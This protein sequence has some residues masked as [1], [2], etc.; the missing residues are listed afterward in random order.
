MYMCIR[1]VFGILTYDIYILRFLSK[2]ICISVLLWSLMFTMHVF[3][4][5]VFVFVQHQEACA[6]CESAINRNHYQCCLK[7][8]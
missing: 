2:I 1:F 8:C 4:T 3:H 5:F 6:P 7:D